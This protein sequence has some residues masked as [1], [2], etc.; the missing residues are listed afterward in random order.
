MIKPDRLGSGGRPFFT[1]SQGGNRTGS[2]QK[3]LIQ[4]FHAR[5][6]AQPTG[7]PRSLNC[8]CAKHVGYTISASCLSNVSVS[9]PGSHFAVAK[10]VRAI[11]FPRLAFPGL[12]RPPCIN[13]SAIRQS[14]CSASACAQIAPAWRPD[15]SQHIAGEGW[16]D[17]QCR[18]WPVALHD[19]FPPPPSPARTLS[20][21][22]CKAVPQRVWPAAYVATACQPSV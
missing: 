7:Q 21:T 2:P 6:G 16:P 1:A 3:T 9:P 22:V 17:R 13:R 4:F 15:D 8:G 19:Q 14:Q 20:Y 11:R 5:A 18:P 10:D 12:P